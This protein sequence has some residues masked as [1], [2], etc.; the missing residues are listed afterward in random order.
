MNVTVQVSGVE[1]NIS[2][3]TQSAYI[4]ME[5]VARIDI[6]NIWQSRRDVR[7]TFL[8]AFGCMLLLIAMESIVELFNKPRT[9]NT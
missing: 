9:S 5:G 2:R 3:V 7:L 6:S 1:L 4:F 8:L